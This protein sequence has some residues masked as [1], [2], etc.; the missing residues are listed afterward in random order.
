MLARIGIKVL[1]LVGITSLLS[2][3]QAQAVC[4]EADKTDCVDRFIS[5]TGTIDFFASGA[6]LAVAEIPNDDR[7]NRV[8]ELGEVRIPAFRIPDRA[9]L[10]SAYLYYGGSLF[11]D[12]DPP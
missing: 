7:P 5:Y 12:N 3:S 11:L 2:S 1:L 4:T 6:S 10:V 9:E 8:L